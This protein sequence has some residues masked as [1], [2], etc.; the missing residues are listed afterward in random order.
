[1]FDGEGKPVK[2]VMEML[3]A[4]TSVVGVDLFGQGEFLA[5]GKTQ[6]SARVV[7]N[8]REFA[9][10]SFAYN[11]TLFARRVHDVMSLISWVS[12]FEEE[13]PQEVMVVAVGGIEPI[14]LAALSQINGVKS[15]TLEN[16]RFRFADLK[17]YRDP[18]FLP[19]AVKYG[20]L[21]ALMKL[22]RTE[23]VK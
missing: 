21:P 18:N 15:I 11:H 22:S 1:M 10:Y 7:K 8:P 12:G 19:G 5:N 9:G 23:V 4:G 6:D 13:K 16:N 17:S 2:A 14:A 3:E 20:D